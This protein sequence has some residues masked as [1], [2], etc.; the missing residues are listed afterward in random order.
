[1][2]QRIGLFFLVFFLIGFI[3][4]GGKKTSADGNADPQNKDTN[5]VK[6]TST[7]TFAQDTMLS[8]LKP[9]LE[10]GLDKW[11]QS[12]PNFHIDSFRQ[13]DIREFQVNDYRE[14]SGMGQFYA[15]YQPSLSYSPI[16]ASSLTCTP[17][18]FHWRKKEKRSLPSAM[19]TRLLRCVTSK[20]KAGRVSYL[21]VHRPVW[22]R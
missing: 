8:S 12:F 10:K 17:A 21:L 3:S 7:N 4:C 15:L 9:L 20:Q 11:I 16:A 13:S 22:K 14:V 5:A 6:Q 19:L 18:G 2:R 1:M